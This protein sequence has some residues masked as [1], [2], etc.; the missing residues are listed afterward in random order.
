MPNLLGSIGDL[1][2]RNKKTI[3]SNA[4]F[5]RN[6]KN[7]ELLT[8]YYEIVNRRGEEKEWEELEEL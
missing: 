1:Y 5:N 8:K 3:I 2:S 4:R 7:E 6:M